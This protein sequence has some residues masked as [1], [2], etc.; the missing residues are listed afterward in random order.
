MNRGMVNVLCSLFFIAGC[1][2]DNNVQSHNNNVGEVVNKHNDIQNLEALDTFIKR[3][4]I[5]KEDTVNY[6][7]YGIEGQ[8]GVT[9]LTSKEDNIHVS[10]SVDKKFI[11]E[12]SCK[13]IA[14]DIE[15]GSDNYVLKQCTGDFEGTRDIPLLTVSK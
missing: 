12:Y 11:E 3:A 5:K 7:E 14:I 1:S 15:N 4:K 2:N 8:R 13:D 10:S 9:T 6:I